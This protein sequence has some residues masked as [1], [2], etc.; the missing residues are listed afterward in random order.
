[1]FN[2]QIFWGRR[3]GV[4]KKTKKN[5]EENK[6]QKEKRK[7]KIRERPFTCFLWQILRGRFVRINHF[8]TIDVNSR[9]NRIHTL[10]VSFTCFPV[11]YSL[12]AEWIHSSDQ[13]AQLLPDEILNLFAETQQLDNL[14]FP[15]TMTTRCTDGSRNLAF[16][17]RQI[18]CPGSFSAV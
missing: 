3:R 7:K 10:T 2:F 13:I 14:N 17:K 11:K 6:T 15:N 16:F 1:M 18:T 8:L 5:T 4:S 12:H 9:T